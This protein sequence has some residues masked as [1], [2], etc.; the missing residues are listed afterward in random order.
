ML[1]YGI[2]DQFFRVLGWV[3]GL[4]LVATIVLGVTGQNTSPPWGE[5]RIGIWYSLDMLLPIIQL[6]KA[7]YDI[8]LKGF[9]RYYFYFH[10][11]MGYLL[12]YVL[13]G[14]LS[15]LTK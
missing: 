14:W 7:H 15:G 6:R 10:K 9:A 5:R 3:V 4:V 8:D 11:L 2:G 1:G 12:G 13:T